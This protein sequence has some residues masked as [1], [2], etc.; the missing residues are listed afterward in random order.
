MGL[1]RVFI[2]GGILRSGSL[3]NSQSSLKVMRELWFT[4]CT[5]NNFVGGLMT[6]RK[7]CWQR[8]LRGVTTLC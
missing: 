7:R 3:R 2:D 6:G 1:F 4:I 5:A 8:F